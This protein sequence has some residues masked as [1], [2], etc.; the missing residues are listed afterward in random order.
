[1]RGRLN[2]VIS[3][4]TGSGKT[5]TAQR[6]VSL[7]PRRRAHRHH[8]GRR[9]AAAAAGARAAAGVAPAEHR[10]PR[11]RS[12]SATWCSNSLR[13]RPDRI[14][15]GEVRDGAAL[16]MLQAMNTGHDGSITTVHANTPARQPLPPRDD[17]AHGRRRPAR[18]RHPRAGRRRRRP[19][20]PA[21]PPQGRHRAASSPSPRSSAWRATSSPCRTCSPSTSRPAAT[22]RAA[23][24]AAC[25]PP[26]CGRSSRRTWPTR[27][28]SLPLAAFS[29]GAR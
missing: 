21:G 1:M 12:R 22:R 16:D 13:M 8:R 28:W 10:G 19:D 7:H 3:G 23:S 9:R 5:T 26:A 27:G 15:V 2:I 20:R 14:V 24:S 25:V 11:R 18:P 6:P 17:G 29:L 4:G